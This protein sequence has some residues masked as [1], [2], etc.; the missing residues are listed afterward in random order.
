MI[1]KLA[2][3]LLAVT[4][5]QAAVTNE[6]FTVTAY[7]RCETC[8]GKWA[9]YGKTANGQTPVEGVTAAAPRRIPFGTIL[10]IEGLGTRVVQDRLSK[11]Y[12]SRIDI[13]FSSHKKALQFGK[14]QLSV[15][16]D[17]APVRGR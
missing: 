12:D 11:K 2:I 6:T 1:T 13:Y 4:T 15:T 9:K 10:K 17:T 5:I 14:Q 7:C 16:Y 8:T 3:L